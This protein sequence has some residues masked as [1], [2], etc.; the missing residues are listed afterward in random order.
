MSFR[1][2]TINVSCVDLTFRTKKETSYEE[3]SQKMKEASLG[4]MAGVLGYTED[5][6]VSTDF[7][8]DTLSSIYDKG[9]GIGLSSNFFKVVSWYDNEA[10]YSNRVLDLAQHISK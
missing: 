9:A 1:V 2:P 5:Q 8:G 7:M 4:E 10:G 3:I 6:V